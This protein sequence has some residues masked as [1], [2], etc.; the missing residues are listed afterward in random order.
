MISTSEKLISPL[1]PTSY[2]Y[3]SYAKFLFMS[4]IINKQTILKF[5]V[6]GPRYTSYPTA[7]VWNESVNES[8]YI[9]KLKA[10]GRGNKTL[11]L[12]IHIPFCQTMCTF[13]GCN[14]VIRK[15]DEKYGDEYLSYLF[16][17]MKLVAGY[18]GRKMKVKQFHLGGG[19]PTFLSEAQLERLFRQ[20]QKYFDIDLTGEIAIEIDPRT[21]DYSKLK[22]LKDL[23]F[24]RISM[25]VQDFT[26]EVQQQ[27]NRIQSF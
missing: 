27:I 15:Q 16:K 1:P 9:E 24:N 13:C 22:K 11:S 18:I 20:V 10:F 8:V 19:T 23:G 7:P 4:I 2:L 14:V 5:D 6:P 25:G 3:T 12:Y 21:I 26:P 17:E